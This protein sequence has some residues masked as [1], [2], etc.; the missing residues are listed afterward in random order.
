M[1]LKNTHWMI[2]QMNPFMKLLIFLRNPITRA[3]SSWQ[4]VKNNEWTNMT[5]EE[6]ISSE[7]KYRQGENRT[8]KTAQ[9]HF[10]QRGLYYGQIVNLLK[11]FPMQ[12]IKIMIIESFSDDMVNEYNEIYDFLGIKKINNAD[13]TK[14]RVNTYDEKLNNDLYKN[15][16]YFYKK[17]V[18]Y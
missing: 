11:W 5:F 15:F 17:D 4:M 9:W 3:Y 12:N 7:L 10:L 16:F 1:Y 13:Y 14:E 8:F 2:Q 6:A 18:E